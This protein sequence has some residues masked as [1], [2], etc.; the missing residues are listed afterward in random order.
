[1]RRQVLAGEIGVPAPPSWSLV[2]P[3]TLLSPNDC[4]T[5]PLKLIPLVL[6][7]MRQFAM[8]AVEAIANNPD[9]LNS[10]TQV[11]T[12]SPK[13]PVLIATPFWLKLKYEL[14]TAAEAWFA[15]TKPEKAAFSQW[16]SFRETAMAPEPAFA[17]KMPLP[18]V[19]LT[20]V[21]LTSS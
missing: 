6:P 12:S 21:F 18:L 2:L 4:T 14:A 7:V 1:M 10:I 5:P 3:L 16:T 13:A 11:S 17:V 20:I 9:V 8:R 15:A 19:S